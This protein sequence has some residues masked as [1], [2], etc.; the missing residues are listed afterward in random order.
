MIRFAASFLILVLRILGTRLIL[1]SH[2]N[3]VRITIGIH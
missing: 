3:K 2:D 1:L